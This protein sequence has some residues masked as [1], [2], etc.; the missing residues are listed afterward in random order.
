MVERNIKNG[1][2]KI[3]EIGG[4]RVSRV[5]YLCPNLGQRRMLYSLAKS[6]LVCFVFFVHSVNSTVLTKPKLCFRWAK[7]SLMLVGRILVGCTIWLVG[8]ELLK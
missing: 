3:M 2:K 1:E 6:P 7:T 8:Q 4:I 5:S